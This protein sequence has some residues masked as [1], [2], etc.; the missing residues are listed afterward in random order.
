MPVNTVSSSSSLLFRLHI[1]RVIFVRSFDVPACHF[2]IRQPS[3]RPI[4]A[5]QPS[6]HILW[7]RDNRS[8]FTR[9][10]IPAHT[11]HT[12]QPPTQ[13]IKMACIASSITNVVAL[14]ATK[15]QVSAAAAAPPPPLFRLPIV[16]GVPAIIFS[17][18]DERNGRSELAARANRV[19]LPRADGV[20]FVSS[21]RDAL[22]RAALSVCGVAPAGLLWFA[23]LVP[24][25]ALGF[26]QLQCFRADNPLTRTRVL[27]PLLPPS[28]SSHRPS[29]C[30]A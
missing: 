1:I 4:T 10:A 16:A 8:T 12:L 3:S 28:R 26:S 23:C 14:K 22:L 30:P 19:R 2:L 13:L 27:T 25:L 24:G 18:G 15:V 5:G 11:P 29:L 7:F 17:L 6:S 21:T 20:S 9:I